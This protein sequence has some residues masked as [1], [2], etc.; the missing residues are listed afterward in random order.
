VRAYDEITRLDP[1]QT[2]LLLTA[3]NKIKEAQEDIT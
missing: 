1:K 3:K 2:T